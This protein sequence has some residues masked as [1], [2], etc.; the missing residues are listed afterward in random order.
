LEAAIQTRIG[1]IGT[2]FIGRVHSLA[3]QNC[4]Q[5][6]LAAVAAVQ[7][8]KLKKFAA[9]FGI[10]RFYTD[11]RELIWEGSVDAV[12]ICT[13]NDLHAPIALAALKANLAVMVEKPMAMSP[14]EGQ[15]M[16]KAAR[17]A[18]APLMVAHCWRFDREVIWLREQASAGRLG[19]IVR[20][21]SYGV[22]AH[23][24][25]S[26]WFTEKRRAG[27]GALVDMGIHGLDT[28]RFLIG[29]PQP[30]SVY[31]RL[32]TY[33]GSYDTDDTGVFLVNWEGGA[34]SYIE[35]GWWQPHTDGPEA[36]AQLYGTLGFGQVFPSYL[37]IS[38]PESPEV[39]R[40]DA[41]MAPREEHGEQQ[42]YDAQMAYFVDCIQTGRTPSPGGEEGLV[43]M[44]ILAAAYESAHTG[45][46][47][48][49]SNQVEI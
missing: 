11:Y 43:N 13:P 46:A 4:P 8:E 26:G 49:L 27:G 37:E 31:A 36:G 20:T 14:E 47:V 29:D 38:N 1:I 6:K 24:G 5:A 22:H 10:K 44:R 21:K 35:S 9:E 41:G 42:M 48:V 15:G 39:E 45:Q 34:V 7:P 30:L 28:A 19:Q 25:P 40:V 16:L 17:Q 3:V 18:G 2:G 12:I 23:W 33:Y 32:G